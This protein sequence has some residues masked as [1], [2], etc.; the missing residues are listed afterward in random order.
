MQGMS[1]CVSVTTM[2][3]S[4]QHGP[5][6]T[7][8][9]DAKRTLLILGASGDLTS[10]L[11]LPGLG[12][13]LAT[14]DVRGLSVIGSALTDWDNDHWRELVAEAFAAVHATG[15]GVDD[16]VQGT[17]YMKADVSVAA[18]LRRL[19]DASEGVAILYFALPPATTMKACRAL[20]DIGLPAGARLVLEKPFGTDAVSAEALNKMLTKLVPED[21]VFRVDHYLGMSTV[22]NILGV[23][24]ANR[25]WEP[26]LNGE[27][28][29]R[30]DVILDECLALEGRAG[31]YDHA[32]ALVD[33]I[34]SHAL[35]V[36]S[37]LTMDAPPT[38]DARD[39]RDR[40]AQL[41]RAT[42]LKNDDPVASSRRARYTA[43]EIDGRY[44]PAYVDEEGVDPAR[45]I[46][47][48]AEVE[49]EIRSWRWAGVPITVRAGKALD[50]LR[51]KIVIT[52]KEPPCVPAG[53]S[54]YETPDRLE[55]GLDPD[56]LLVRLNVNGPEDPMTISSLG[57]DATLCPGSLPPYGQVLEAI[58][59]GD[60]SLSVRGDTAVD[61]WRIIDPVRKAWC[62][63]K[64]AMGEYA[65]GSKAPG[66]I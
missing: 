62:D 18:D 26:L 13:L 40:K 32:G 33:M 2:S 31:Y 27:H 63:G 46:E 9:G 30:I 54:G 5:R 20:V 39:L 35:Q 47:T 3:A 53:L 12:G 55:I 1:F 41:L 57:L 60:P 19:L 10:R 6:R 15:A 43:G 64:V 50:A 37:L 11:L 28:V 17:R 16:V 65:A 59:D 58:L 8:P 51:K 29:G 14:G 21:Q 7:P 48:F 44:L 23:R 45:M 49:L 56:R 52:F 22:L 66:V 25:M 42:Y 38:L 34:Q 4:T 36:L 24:F 61:C